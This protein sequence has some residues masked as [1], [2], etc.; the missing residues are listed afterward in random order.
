[1]FIDT[2]AYTTYLFGQIYLDKNLDYISQYAEQEDKIDLYILM[3]SNVEFVQ[4]GGRILEEQSRRDKFFDDMKSF[5]DMNNKNYVIIDS[6]SYKKR[7]H[8]A[9]WSVFKEFY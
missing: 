5:L 1:M 6:D 4:D 2:E 3:K 8:E 9:V 7:Q